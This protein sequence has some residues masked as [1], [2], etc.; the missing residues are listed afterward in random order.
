MPLKHVKHYMRFTLMSSNFAIDVSTFYLKREHLAE[1][2]QFLQKYWQNQN[3]QFH[4]S[5]VLYPTFCSMIQPS[6]VQGNIAESMPL[7][8]Q[9]WKNTLLG[10]DQDKVDEIMQKKWESWSLSIFCMLFPYHGWNV[11]SWSDH[12]KIVCRRCWAF[13]E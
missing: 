12:N 4:S 5:L 9:K 13:E 6:Y 11:W 7:S 8:L 2:Y 3:A 10:L 1:M